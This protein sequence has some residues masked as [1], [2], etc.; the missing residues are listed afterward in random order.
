MKSIKTIF[1]ILACISFIIVTG[2]A[3][4]EHSAVIPRWKLAPPA[5]LTMFQGEYGLN[6]AIFWQSVHPIT[7]LLLIIAMVLNWKNASRKFIIISII[8]YLIVGLVTF[9]YF[10]PELLSIIHTDYQ[11]VIDQSLVARA[12][13]WEKLSLV[14]LVFMIAVAMI[15]LYSLTKQKDSRVSLIK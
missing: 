9:V 5:S 10:V 4:Y 11:P 13:T 1:L 14:R 12:S 3:V 8:G 15:L 6:Q 2:G 7:L